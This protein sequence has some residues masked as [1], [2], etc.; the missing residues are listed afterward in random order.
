MSSEILEIIVR[1]MDVSE[2]IKNWKQLSP[3]EILIRTILSQNTTEQNALAAFNMLKTTFSNKIDPA[4]LAYADVT[5][6]QEAIRIAGLQNQKSQRI[7]TISR[8][9]HY[10]W[11]GNFNFI[12]KAPLE[13]V[14]RKI[15]DLPGIGKKTADVLLNFCGKRPILPVDTHINRISKRIGLVS[16]NAQ[17]DEVRRSIERFIAP[18]KIVVIHISLIFF[19]QK[20]C[21]TL[22]PKCATCPVTKLC[23][24]IGVKTTITNDH[25]E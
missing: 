4:T 6:I 23:P 24:K 15:M 18:D 8:T 10:D 22:K 1:E 17:Y 13:E 5:K 20:V 19:G 3:F 21:K 11:K 7:K 14:R 2:Y 12:Y 25:G 16:Q 9:I